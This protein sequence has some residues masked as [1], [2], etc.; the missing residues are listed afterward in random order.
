M[1]EK[2]YRTNLN[3][4]ISALRNSVPSLRAM[5]NRAEAQGED[6]LDDGLSSAQKL[7]KATILSKATEYIRHLER[8][9]DKLSWENAELKDR[10]SRLETMVLNSVNTFA[11]ADNNRFPP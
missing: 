2:R 1:I 10:V 6:A 7:S 4:K 5:M 9:N 3:D 11:D 8:K